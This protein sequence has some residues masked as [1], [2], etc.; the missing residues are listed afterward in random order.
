LDEKGDMRAPDSAALYKHSAMREAGAVARAAL[1]AEL[2]RIGFGIEAM[3]GRGGRYFEI[4]GGPGGLRERVSSRRPEVREW[5]AERTR[6]RGG[7]LS[8]REAS[9]AA[10]ATRGAKHPDLSKAFTQEIWRSLAQDFFFDR[11]KIEG[12]LAAVK[13][14]REL[15]EVTEEVRAT[16]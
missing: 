8:G 4:E 9:R 5:I 1:A 12:L 13:V 16:I 6:Q 10:M 7:E 14:A 2:K 3:T 15:D 11:R